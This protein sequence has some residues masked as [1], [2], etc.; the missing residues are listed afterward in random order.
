M[1]LSHTVFQVGTLVIIPQKI[2]QKN[3][4]GSSITTEKVFF[5]LADDVAL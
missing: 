4:K 2:F 1:F 5:K 3:T